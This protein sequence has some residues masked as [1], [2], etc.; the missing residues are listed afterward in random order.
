[1]MIGRALF[2]LQ[3]APW[4]MG[5]PDRISVHLQGIASL[6][7]IRLRNLAAPGFGPILPVFANGASILTTGPIIAYDAP[8]QAGV[9]T[10]T[11]STAA[12]VPEPT[13]RC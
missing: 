4:S 6:C 1:M 5:Q 13:G 8:V 11:V 9:W 7:V 12:D 10:A 2:R 3:S